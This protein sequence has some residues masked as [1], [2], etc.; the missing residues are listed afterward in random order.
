MEAYIGIAVKA[1][2]VLPK[3]NVIAGDK[4]ATPM[5]IMK[6]GVVIKMDNSLFLIAVYV[7]EL[8]QV[9]YPILMYDV[10][11]APIINPNNLILVLNPGNTELL[12]NK[13]RYIAFPI[14]GLETSEQINI[15]ES[16]I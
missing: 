1:K 4:Q 6:D 14:P 3:G 16:Q 11:N 2:D 8:K 15:K 9:V 5:D 7:S 12:N 13:F 10:G